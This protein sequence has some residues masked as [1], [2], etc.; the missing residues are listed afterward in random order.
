[1]E[2]TEARILT[3]TL[4]KAIKNAE[5]QWKVE[6]D[7]DM[8]DA[9]ERGGYKTRDLKL[10]GKKVGTASLVMKPEGPVIVDRQ[11]FNEWALEN[12]LAYTEVKVVKDWEKLCVIV[13]GVAVLKSTG[14]EVPGVE[15][16]GERPSHVMIRGCEPEDVMPIIQANPSLFFDVI[17][18]VPLLEGGE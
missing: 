15:I 7:S 1:M 16:R 14:E 6:F 9:Y 10:G 3:K 18:E 4:S 13:D 8:F 12:G 5:D 2:A 17:T 11:R